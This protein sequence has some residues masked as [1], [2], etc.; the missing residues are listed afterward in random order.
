MSD[1]LRRHQWVDMVSVQL[2]IGI[3]TQ[4]RFALARL[5]HTRWSRRHNLMLFHMWAE[6][7]HDAGFRRTRQGE[8][9][10]EIDP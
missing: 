6:H 7:Y 5:L 4:G 3:V 2:S 10:G 9:G 8:D 1:S